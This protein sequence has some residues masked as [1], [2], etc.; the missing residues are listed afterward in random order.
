MTHLSAPPAHPEPGASVAEAVSAAFRE[1]W[2]QI[3]ATLVPVTGD[4]DVAEECAQ[5]AFAKAVERWP[6]DGVPRR[7]GA[8]LTTT[9]RNRAID[10]RRRDA[11]G[12]EKLRQAVQL[13]QWGEPAAHEEWEPGAIADERLRLLF[14]CCHPALPPETSIALALR[15]VAG[16]ST[17]AIARAFQVS[18]K[19]MS[20][21]LVRARN[22]IRT[23]AIPFCVPPA[24]QLAERTG[25]VRGVLGVM[26]GSGQRQEAIRLARALV[27]LMPQD[28]EARGLLAC[29][30]RH[31][32]QP[33][34]EG[35]EGHG[36]ARRTSASFLFS[37]CP[38]CEIS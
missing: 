18:E 9:A 31:E 32:K 12:R 24:H 27:Q 10:R 2:G 25:A 23:A 36:K 15:T 4:W 33:H 6:S 38:L 16:L 29:M 30:L 37:P 13:W 28:A 34:T 21:R 7:P 5:D 22:R 35:T 3:V 11:L 1:Q 19:T 26:F 8:W 17:N 14:A 20:K